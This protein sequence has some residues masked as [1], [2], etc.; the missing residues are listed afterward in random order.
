[1]TLI[2]GKSER[3]SGHSLI[4]ELPTKTT[5][6]DR[7]GLTRSLSSNARISDSN[8][9]GTVMALVGGVI[10][11]RKHAVAPSAEATT[12][13]RRRILAARR[14]AATAQFIGDLGLLTVNCPVQRRPL[15][16]RV[17]DIGAGATIEQ[18]PDHVVPT[19]R[20]RV[21]QRGCVR[22]KP[23]RTKSIGIFAC[24]EQNSHDVGVTLLRSECERDVLAA[25]VRAWQ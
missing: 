10:V 7:G 23:F 19:G 16:D 8:R 25:L 2:P 9:A 20:N 12:S 14:R 1:M 11:P 17:L 24:I 15:E 6:T 22:V 3:R 18:Q 4:D 13:A 5:P 21:V